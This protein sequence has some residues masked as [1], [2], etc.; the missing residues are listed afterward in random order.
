MTKLRKTM[1]A[2]LSVTMAATMAASQVIA[3]ANNSYGPAAISERV[4]KG[5]F[6]DV[7]GSLDLSE[8]SRSQLAENVVDYGDDADTK[9]KDGSR[10]TTATVIVSLETPSVTESKGDDMTVSEYL[11]TSA[12]SRAL[13]NITNAQDS[14]FKKL[15]SAGIAYKEVARYSTVMSGVA[16]EVNTAQFKKIKNFAN[17]SMVGVSK[18]YAALEVQNP[19]I[20][21]SN[22]YG[23]GIYDSSEI[24]SEY[25]I[26]GSGITV[27][28]LDTGLDY[29]H[30]AFSHDPDE[31]AF[32]RN[33]ISNILSEGNLAAAQRSPG[34][35]VDDLY[36]SAKVPFAYD[37]ADDDTDV[38]PSYSQH[39]VHVAGIVAGEADTYIDKDGNVIGDDEGEVGF[40]GAAPGAQLVI[41]KV[42]TDD[43]N[44]DDIGGATSEDIIAA[45]DDC[46]TLGVDIINMSL[47]T[48][49]GFSNVS[50]EGDEEGAQLARVYQSI[51]DEGISLIA[52]AGNEFSSGFGSEFGTNLAS[53]PDS[54]TVGSPSTFVGAMSVAS[55][56]GQPASYMVSNPNED[57]KY[58]S[59]P[60]YYNESN[61]SNAVPFD[62]AEE[63]LGD[64]E[65][66]TFRYFVIPGVGNAADYTAVK[67]ILKN[68]GNEKILVV[69]RRGTT[70]FKEKVETAHDA[71]ADGIIVYN[72]V[73]GTIRMSLS[74]IEEDLRIPSASVNMDA[75]T[76]LTA[77]PND[78][79]RLRTEGTI[80]INKTYLAGPFMNDYS[81]WGATPD[82]KLKPDITSHGGDIT[83]AVAGGYEEMS[84]TSMATPNLAGLMALVRSHLRK[85]NPGI[86]AAELTKLSNQ[87]V[88]SS[89]T[90][91]YDEEKLPYSP[92]KQGAGLATLNNIFT[93]NAYLST[94]E[95]NGGA[96]DDRPK[97]E[98]GEDEKKSGVYEF[99]FKV[100]NFGNE[101][102]KFNLVSRFMTETIAADGLA[103]AEAAYMLND[104][105]AVFTV[106]GA[107]R[108]N[109][110]ITV[111]KNSTAEITV[112]LTL[113]AAE[114]SYLDH[115]FIHGM[116]VEGFISLVSQS[117]GQC[118]LNL[119]FMGFYGDW[120][121]APMLDYNA[122]EISAIQ[123]DTSLT[124]DEKPHESVFATQLFS[125]YYNGKY[126]VPMGG[127]AYLQN[128]SDDVEKVYVT[129]EHCAISRYNEYHGP[130]ATNNYMTSTGLRALYAGLLR[131]AELVTYDIYNVDTGEIVYQGNSYRIGK[132]IANGG[133]ATP[134]LLDLRLDTEDLGLIN[135]GKYQVEF[136]FYMKATEKGTA[137]PYDNTFSSVFY[138]DYDA[139]ILE[140]T[141][142]R[143]YD[144]QDGN[145]NKQR[146]YLDIDIYDNHYPQAVMLCYSEEEYDPDSDEAAIVNIA[147][148]YVT[149]VYNPVRNSTNTVSIEI[150]DIY[151]KYGNKLY[152]QIDDYALNHSVYTLNFDNSNSQ[153]QADD[154]NFVL[155]D[156][157]TRTQGNRPG[158]YTY[159]LTLDVNEMYRV[160]LDCGN[161]SLSNY[162]WATQR[163]DILKVKNG[164]IFGIRPGTARVDVT[165]TA[166]DSSGNK[167]NKT[168]TLN[169]TVVESTRTLPVPT[170]SFGL[171]Q[172]TNKELKIA[173]GTVAVNAGQTFTLE[174]ISDPW[175]YPVE[176][177]NLQW[178]SSNENIATVDQNGLVTTK[179][180]R[181]TAA[182]RATVM[183]NGM[184]TQYAAAVTL[185]VADPF[186]ISSTIL[187]KYHG[188]EETVIIPDDENVMY[189]G[190]EAFKDNKTMKRVVIPRT[191]VQIMERAF[192]NC[193]ALEEVYFINI[194]DE[195]SEPETDLAAISL[196]LAGAFSGCENLKLVD[197][198]NIKVVTVADMAFAGCTELETVRHMEKIGIAGNMAFAGCTKL[199]EADISGLHTSGIGVFDSCT[200]LTSVKTAHYTSMGEGMFHECTSLKE[201]V[202]NNPRVP[203]SAFEGCSSLQ[204]V[205]FGGAE[206]WDNTI[207]KIDAYAFKDCTELET[208]E[209]KGYD[210]S[211]I[212]DGAFENTAI[213]KFT[214]PSGNPVLGEKIF[215]DK[216]VAIEWGNEY[217]NENGAIYSGTKLVKAPSEITSGFAIKADTTVIGAYAFADSKFAAE[218]TTISIPATVTTIEQ[219]AFVGAPIKSIALPAGV[220]VIPDYAFMNSG[221]VSVQIP[222]T[223]TSIG[224]GAFAEC[225]NLETVTFAEN[226]ELKF[227]GDGAFSNTAIINITLPDGV[228]TM[229]SFVF[230][231]CSELKNAHLPSVK[232][233]GGYTFEECP[234]LESVTFGANA[235]SSGV[236]TFFPG[237]DRYEVD[238]NGNL[239]TIFK[240]SALTTVDLGGL[241]K[242]DEG[243][244]YACAGLTQIDL[245]NV[246]E[247][248]SGV[249][250]E[251]TNL[252]TVINLDK[253]TYI[254]DIAF[255]ACTSLKE[256]NLHSAEH[257]GAQA[258]INVEATS[259]DVSSVKEIGKQAFA[260][261]QIT[262]LSLPA[263]LQS[264]GD[265]AFMAAAV[266]RLVSIDSNNKVFFVKDNVLYRNITTRTGEVGYELC[267]Y[268]A[269]R[270][271]TS[272]TVIDETSSIQGYAFA[273]TNSRLTTVTLPY[274]VKVIGICAFYGSG[275][276]TYN[277]YSINAP[278]LLSEYYVTGLEASAFY[279]LYYANFNL[280]ILEFSPDIVAGA[281]ESDLTIAYPSNGVGYDN[282]V[283]RK[284]FGITVNLGEVEDDTTRELINLID[285]FDIEKINSWLTLEVNEE[286]TKMVT[287]FSQKV[288][289]AHSLYLN[290]I[291]SEVQLGFLT[292]ARIQKLTDVETAL[293]PVK[294]RFGISPKVSNINVASDSAHKSKYI[295]GEYFDMTGL[296]LE[297]TFDDYTSVRISDTSQMTLLPKYM[298]AL[299]TYN[300]YVE[301]SYGDAYVRISITVS[302]EEEIDPPV[303]PVTSGDGGSNCSGCGSMDI[304][305]TI[306]GTGL[307]L[308]ALAGAL[309][310]VQK[311]R[312]KA[313]KN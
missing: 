175:Y 53:N 149:P 92:R 275:I 307:M 163:S 54:G 79:T 86:Q 65:S 198:T 252:A 50:I 201:V 134:A 199:K 234:K 277:F 207:F 43:L 262:E 279:T 154:F 29:T 17:V 111:A 49:S 237:V 195:N 56:N 117:E 16:I 184:A 221:L 39:G 125:T 137:V 231:H 11:S 37:Y 191:T 88:M 290:I 98:L 282:Y 136:N 295:A 210:V 145:K 67:D 36:L 85:Q 147:T 196:I 24:K 51:K 112:K 73:P 159:N 28:I 181:G 32:T 44:S 153:N 20:N 100:T 164:E 219:G 294:D 189:I 276:T 174:I 263:T 217:T 110:T 22:V 4:Q 58:A 123:Q 1:L 60:I 64:A 148:E 272:Y 132:A 177:L 203:G 109:D 306:G 255:A 101:Q 150:T 143:Y 169:V 152:I 183:E 138:V 116:Y 76:A 115:N 311:I 35:T 232:S 140:G 105:P 266:L 278:R 66:A 179:N 121:S 309:L 310:I 82:L 62:F 23:T 83:S 178:T 235:T 300:T 128:E 113:S 240:D 96:E 194:T 212:G 18:T 7:T 250:A 118:D 15:S 218:V 119:P 205:T 3:Y 251:C 211:Y 224:E 59:T 265:G 46:V 80:V 172:G 156:R 106:K 126:A 216:T 264:Y 94:D 2:A 246:K 5:S 97:I 68:K 249:F 239:V 215:G 30:E 313:N 146:V 26:D 287:E 142:I 260:G 114:K 222:A 99:T 243:A 91:V 297:V 69:V 197:L 40:F 204:K 267:L 214:M 14:F 298:V 296:I 180:T 228:A 173:R 291:S 241:T 283:F 233:L 52:A 285:S 108:S 208:V 223:I 55:I 160:Q 13:K 129:E 284:Y 61:D 42:F 157:V 139:P 242:L 90:L 188:S 21:P 78:P 238:E 220:T 144:Y 155:N 165:G 120:E 84:G 273:Y 258:F 202:I 158:E 71:G 10:N 270:V 72:N 226:S 176:T 245:K 236:Y 206:T 170:L 63:L 127:F 259:L 292:K 280:T 74:D 122:Y 230:Y 229:G 190:E 45:L 171:V 256:L 151:E 81:S 130:T 247:I 166:I 225:E 281:V 271:A 257:I 244:F 12:G 301:V 312:R 34:V 308:L 288:I 253:V 27:A 269:G 162:T 33:H 182:I 304:G 186:D 227:I 47:G 9:T 107:D 57:N 168:L 31:V 41:C 185:S 274:S 187:N 161:A 102:L 286:N 38:Y 6:T 124:D 19:Q 261:I 248:G 8:I 289:R 48:T 193:T 89:A 305:S 133:T 75:G 254:G 167:V 104:N 141:R 103:V 293:K 131:N 268:P 87:I 77:N 209:F 213:T 200:S 95:K 135:N 302:A 299:R 303:P 192:L 70:S 25:G 93:T